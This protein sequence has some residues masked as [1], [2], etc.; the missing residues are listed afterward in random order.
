M[1]KIGVQKYSIQTVYACKYTNDPE[2]GSVKWT[3]VKGEGNAVVAGTW[4]VKPGKEKSAQLTIKTKGEME[5]PLPGML[6]MVLAPIVRSEFERLVDQYIQNLTKSLES[7]KLPP[8]KK[9]AAKK[10]PGK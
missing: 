10:R 4:R 5:I 9:A 8:R 1:E 7:G 6:R 3:P 2:K